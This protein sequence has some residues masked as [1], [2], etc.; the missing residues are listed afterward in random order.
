MSSSG[1]SERSTLYRTLLAPRALTD[2][3]RIYEYIA[4]DAPLAAERW[5]E[6]IFE[7]V[8]GLSRFPRRCAHAPEDEGLRIGLRQ[9]V[10]GNYRILFTIDEER[11]LVKV[12]HIRHG[13][14][15]A[16]TADDLAEEEE[17]P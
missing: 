1:D 9:L 7:A 11:R 12:P 13:A 5:V 16:L 10:H 17:A 2:V 6:S 14:R 3:E 8:E 15:R 4:A